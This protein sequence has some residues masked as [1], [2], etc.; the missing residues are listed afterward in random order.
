MNLHIFNFLLLSVLSLGIVSSEQASMTDS[1]Y[2]LIAEIPGNLE[3]FVKENPKSAVAL[4]VAL[5]SVIIFKDVVVSGAKKTVKMVKANPVVSFGVSLIVA[6]AVYAYWD[7][8]YNHEPDLLE[9]ALNSL[10]GGVKSVSDGLA[11]G[12]SQVKSWYTSSKKEFGH[13]TY[14]SAEEARGVVAKAKEQFLQK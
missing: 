10:Q 6:G 12:C 2:A 3:H 8:Y 13:M 9:K 14:K 1:A 7:H 5:S 11:S 4:I